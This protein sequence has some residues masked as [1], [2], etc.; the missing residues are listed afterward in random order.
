MKVPRT[1][2]RRLPTGV[3]TLPQVFAGGLALESFLERFGIESVVIGSQHFVGGA[4]IVSLGAKLSVP[5]SG[6][7]STIRTCTVVFI[8]PAFSTQTFRVDGSGLHR[9]TSIRFSLPGMNLARQ[10][11]APLRHSVKTGLSVRSPGLLHF[12]DERSKCPECPFRRPKQHVAS[13][14]L[15]ALI[16]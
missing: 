8:V 2:T 11:T 13:S 4:G 16:R 12:N 3:W 1:I 14:P 9:A 7:E 5:A 10:L 15:V 6:R